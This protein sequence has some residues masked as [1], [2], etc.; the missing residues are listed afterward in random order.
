MERV[1]LA[2]SGGLETSA[3]ISWLKSRHG[4]DVVAVTMDLGEGRALEPVRDRALALGAVR[5]HVLDLREEFARTIL[6][7]A[8][9]AD[10]LYDDRSPMVAALARPLI[11]R[12]LVEIAEIEHAGAVAHGGGAAG[13]R[14]PLDHLLRALDPKL[15]ILA[16]VRE[17]NMTREQV[18]DYARQHAVALPPTALGPYKIESNLWGRS[19]ECRELDDASQE[20][21]EAIYTLTRP[22]RECPDEPAYVELTFERGVPAAINGVTMPF[23]DLIGSLVT[24]ASAHGVGR[25]DV[26]EHRVGTAKVRELSEAPAAVLLHAAH[27]E[28]RKVSASRDLERFSRTVSAEYADLIYGGQWFSP[29]RAALDGF[30]EAVQQHLSG[31]VRLKLFKGGYSIV[32][33]TPTD[34]PSNAKHS[35]I[36]RMA[37]V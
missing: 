31:V 18:I 32:G 22:A 28:L 35:A 25:I 21:P 8:L 19:I 1:V 20:P 16:P 12:R 30:V 13:R 26:V 36:I 33:R 7:P 23:L 2:Y 29:L 6:L 15:K 34:A 5:A 9:K 14:I 27:R 11:A 24:I 10:A 4:V 3:A 17:W 37:K